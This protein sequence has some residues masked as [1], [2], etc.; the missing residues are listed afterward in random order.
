MKQ[1]EGESDTPGMTNGKAGFAAP[2]ANNLRPKKKNAQRN[3]GVE[4][5]NRSVGITQSGESERDAVGDGE[6]ADCLDEHPAVLH[7]Q[8]EAEEKKKMVGAEGDVAN[9][10]NNVA[11]H[12]NQVALR[13]RNFDVR[14]RRMN[15]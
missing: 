4:R 3:C 1:S 6:S 13:G 9:S 11:A 2:D 7:D 14:L 15:Y 8:Q 10:V 5:Y 12:D